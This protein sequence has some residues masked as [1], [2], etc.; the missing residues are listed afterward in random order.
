M[1]SFQT[2]SL[3]LYIP[4]FSAL[5]LSSAASPLQFLGS[6]AST[7]PKMACGSGIS[8]I[9][10]NFKHII[11]TVSKSNTRCSSLQALLPIAGP[12]VQVCHFWVWLLALQ[13]RIR[14]QVCSGV[15]LL[16]IHRDT[17]FY[18]IYSSV[19]DLAVILTSAMTSAVV[20]LSGRVSCSPG[21]V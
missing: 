5:N 3:K 10:A 18:N 19:D 11:I 21:W 2:M 15:G 9:C 12:L 1:Y 6:P 16:K 4:C 20:A 7:I 8:N 13:A 14:P 17:L